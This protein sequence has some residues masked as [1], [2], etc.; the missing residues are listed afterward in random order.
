MITMD[1]KALI[2]SVIDLYKAAREIKLSFTYDNEKIRRGRSHTIASLTEDLF[3]YF[4]I[5][6][7]PQVDKIVI[8]QPISFRSTEKARTI[9]PDLALIQNGTINTILD[10]KMDLGRKR[11]EVVNLFKGAQNIVREM[12]GKQVWYRDGI[13]KQLFH[14]TVTGNVKYFIVVFSRQNINQAF[15]NSE[16]EKLQSS[17]ICNAQFYFLTDKAHPNSQNTEAAKISI[18]VLPDFDKLLDELNERT[19]GVLLQAGGEEQ[20]ISF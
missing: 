10:I 19:T 11:S 3:A 14:A 15:L 12:R 9:Y 17:Y 6:K 8:D 16:I 13:T 1:K 5:N 2:E 20:V 7:F 4:L 18:E